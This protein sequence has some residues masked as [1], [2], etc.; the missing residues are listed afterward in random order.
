M[1]V[2]KKDLLHTNVNLAPG[3]QEEH[4]TRQLLKNEDTCTSTL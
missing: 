2:P 4:I 1:H 3:L